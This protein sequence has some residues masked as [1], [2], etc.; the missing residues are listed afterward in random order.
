MPEARRACSAMS[1]R[2]DRVQIPKSRIQA[3]ALEYRMFR[4]TRRRR[5]E[6][7]PV[8]ASH[9]LR[10]SAAFRDYT[11]AELGGWN[12]HAHALDPTNR[13]LVQPPRRASAP[14]R[15]SGQRQ[16]QAHGADQGHVA[17]HPIHKNR[18]RIAPHCRLPMVCAQVCPELASSNDQRR[19]LPIPIPFP[20]CLAQ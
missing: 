12:H 11:L 8:R 4:I 5:G 9:R 10:P 20:R 14:F 1:T 16:D 19:H 17:G 18:P 6:S 2:T 3:A 15:Q 7:R 13:I